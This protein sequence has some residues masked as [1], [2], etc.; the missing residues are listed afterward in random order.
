MKVNIYRQVKLYERKIL[1]GLLCLLLFYR[2]S[3]ETKDVFPKYPEVSKASQT[4]RVGSYD[5]KFI[6]FSRLFLN[7]IAENTHSIFNFLKLLACL[8]LIL[9]R[10]TNCLL[11]GNLVSIFAN[12]PGQFNELQQKIMNQNEVLTSTVEP[13]TN[14]TTA[15]SSFTS[16]VVNVST[17]AIS[18]NTSLTTLSVSTSPNSANTSI[19][20]D[21]IPTTTV[22][23][24]YRTSKLTLDDFSN[25]MPDLIRIMEPD[26]LYVADFVI[27]GFFFISFVQVLAVISGA[28]ITNMVSYVCLYI[29]YRRRFSIPYSYDFP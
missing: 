3:K 15:S 14:L 18:N 29:K 19:A 27:Y 4:S 11:V 26:A 8:I 24:N 5:L 20:N 7:D 28:N 16:S 6:I 9:Y 23:P 21:T 10:S 2:G 25:A 12:D 13:S 22:S 17:V 1:N